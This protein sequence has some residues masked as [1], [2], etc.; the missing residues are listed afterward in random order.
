MNFTPRN[1]L[2]RGLI[3]LGDYALGLGFKVHAF[4]AGEFNMGAGFK[5]EG[6]CKEIRSSQP[7]VHVEGVGNL[8]DRATCWED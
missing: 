8:H 4:P 5:C 1:L 2:N 7:S 6:C 3:T